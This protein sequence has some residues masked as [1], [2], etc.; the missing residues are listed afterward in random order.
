MLIPFFLHKKNLV[1]L[2]SLILLISCSSDSGNGGGSGNGTSTKPSNLIVSASVIGT[3]TQNPN[4]DGSGMVN[5]NISAANA[6]SFKIALGDGN[7]QDATNGTYTYT[8]TAGGINTYVVYV[9]AYNGASFVST[10][11]TVTLYVAP[12]SIWSDEFNSNGAPNPAKWGYDLGAGGWGNNESQYYT[13]RSDNV[14]VENGLLKIIT[15]KENYQGSSHTSARLLSKGKFSFK[16]GKVEIR[17]KLPAGGGT[18]PA[19][20]MLGDNLDTA[21][22]PACGEIDIMEHKGNQLNKIYS[23]LHYTGHSGGSGDSSNITLSTADATSA[24]HLYTLDWREDVIKFYVDNQL[25]K[26]FVNSSSLPFNQ[27]F[28]LIINCAMGGSFGGTIDPSFTS[29]TFEI[30]YVRV[31]N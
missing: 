11:V 16:Y 10:S 1:S 28:F 5:F 13:N 27:K 18:W 19:L 20:W 6:T 21:G 9:S 7:T 22:W 26:T 24:F 31:Y 17:A 15:K 23:T 3:N 29:S 14:I 12:T 25:F 4:G 30:D 8:Y 2:L